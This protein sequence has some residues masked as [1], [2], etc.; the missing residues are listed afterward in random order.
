M[1][2]LNKVSCTQKSEYELDKDLGLFII[3]SKKDTSLPLEHQHHLSIDQET[4]DR[5]RKYSLLDINVEGRN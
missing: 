5:V 4:I 2:N 1:I 3:K